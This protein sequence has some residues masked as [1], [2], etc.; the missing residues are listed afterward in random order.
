MVLS[1]PIHQAGDT[2][3][4]GDEG[5]A[6]TG[7]L[8][9][10]LTASIKDVY[11][12]IIQHTNALN[13]INDTRNLLFNTTFL[14]GIQP[15]FDPQ[16]FIGTNNVDDQRVITKG[17]VKALITAASSSAL[18]YGGF[19]FFKYSDTAANAEASIE[20]NSYKSQHVPGPWTAL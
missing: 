8:N 15:Y 9:L 10:K 17:Q 20:A 16:I 14:G 4:G 3:V 13:T 11:G 7:S 19:T 18:Y 5:V 2:F 1:N 6:G 12:P